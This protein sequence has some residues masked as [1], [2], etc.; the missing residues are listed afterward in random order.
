MI[1][2]PLQSLPQVYSC[3]RELFWRKSSLNDGTLL[4]FL[5]ISAKLW[6]KKCTLTSFV[7]LE[8]PLKGNA[9]KNGGPTVGFS[10]TTMLQHTG[11]YWPKISQQRASWQHWSIPHTLLTLLQL[12]FTCSLDS[13]QHGRN[14]ALVMALTQSRMRWK[15]W[16]GFHKT[17]SRNDS[18]T[19][20]VVGR[21]YS[22]RRGLFWWKCILN[23][24]MFCTSQKQNYLGSILNLSRI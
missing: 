5:E 7:V 20:T 10:F 16:K 23:D 8:T 12:I 2:T 14:G 13:K 18:N 6:I 22:C 9:P 17:V 1:P 15:S 19:F 11:R 24:V 4:Y 21:A 3:R